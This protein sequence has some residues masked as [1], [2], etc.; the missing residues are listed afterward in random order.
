MTRAIEADLSDTLVI[1][2]ENVFLVTRRGGGLPLDDEHAFGLWYR[3]CRFLSGYRLLVNGESPA[4]LQ[5]SDALGTRTLH[6]MTNPELPVAPGESLPAQSVSLRCE[7]LVRAPGSL[8]ERLA[9]CNHHGQTVRLRLEVQLAADFKPMLVARGIVAPSE[10][11]R[12][13]VERDGTGLRFSELGRDGVLRT[14]AI[15]PSVEPA[16]AELAPGAGQHTAATAVLRFEVDVPAEGTSEL[17]IDFTASELPDGPAGCAAPRTARDR[18][19]IR[20]HD[21]LFDRVLARS[22]RDLDMLRSQLDGR[23]YYSA[24]VPWYATLFGRDGLIGAMQMLAFGPE[25]AADTLRLLGGLLGREVDDTRDE[26]PGRVLHEL[27]VGE[28]AALGETPFARYY[29]TAD[30]TPLWLSLLSDHAGWSG[31]L[32]LFHELRPQVDAALDWME[33][34]GDIDGDGLIEYL[35]RAP[36]GLVNQGWR[37]SRDGVPYADGTPLE[38]PVAVVEV[39][40]Y[41]IRA[42]RGVARLFELDGDGERAERLRARAD[43]LQPALEQFWA[44][45]AASYAIGLDGEK[46]PGSALTSNPGHLL[47]A[48]AISR[49]RARRVRDVLMGE[50]MFSGWG[51]RTLAAGHPAYNPIGYHMGSVWPHD[52]ALIACGLREYGFDKDFDRLFGAL[53]EASSRFADFRLPELFG[54]HERR[55]GESPV[56]YPVACRPQAW[57]AGAIP[58]LLSTGL[59]LHADGLSRRLRVVRPA[60]PLRL[61]W[62]QVEA[63]RV[64]GASVDL[65]FER[66]GDDVELVDASVEGELELVVDYGGEV[67]VT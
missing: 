29:G 15:E 10:R 50:R 56:P 25:V 46:R 30:A 4:L 2:D 59:G 43:R 8:R 31:T 44:P 65:R 37:D 61:E 11:P 26:Q 60:L 38:P 21:E 67:Q 23:S 47:W 12:A 16:V 35:R 53:L 9:L 3:D 19:R 18:T 5:A 7:R 36:Q 48:G 33:R 52:N 45:G 34:Y 20:S 66:S 39:Q 41:A 6:D 28:P 27:R 22:L 1:K 42:L 51:V 13:R 57:A 55:P 58:Y 24:G 62:L 14:T 63:L 64:A 17:T 49:G 32:D 40:G 54:G